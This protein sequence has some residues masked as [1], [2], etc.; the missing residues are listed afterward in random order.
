MYLREITTCKMENVNA[1]VSAGCGEA[2]YSK[3]RKQHEGWTN[4]SKE[5]IKL[6][7]YDCQ[8]CILLTAFV[9]N[10][11][12]AGCSRQKKKEKGRIC[13]PQLNRVSSRR[14]SLDRRKADKVD[15][16]VDVREN[17]EKLI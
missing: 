5:I 3:G 11:Q 1:E 17:K 9:Q 14:D 10:H 4:K 15:R 12:A 6:S 8:R 13:A 16:A 7:A 2:T